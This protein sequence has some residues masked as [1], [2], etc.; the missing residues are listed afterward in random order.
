MPVY[1][2]KIRLNRDSYHL[3]TAGR[4]PVGC[5]WIETITG[6]DVRN[7][8]YKPENENFKVEVLLPD[9]SISNK[10]M[11]YYYDEMDSETARLIR[12]VAHTASQKFNLQKVR[13]LEASSLD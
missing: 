11:E 7:A 8:I 6:Y 5:V 2:G 13:T 10:K 1:E 4:Y 9:E 12:E 3:F